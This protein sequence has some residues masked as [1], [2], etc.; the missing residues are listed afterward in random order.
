MSDRGLYSALYGQ[1][2]DC[3][4]LIDDVI[5]DLETAGRVSTEKRRRTLSGYFRALEAAP[6]SNVSAALLWNVLCENKAQ[7]RADWSEV[8]D[9]ID[10]CDASDGVM[11]QL[12]DLAQ[13]LEVERAELN[14][15]IRGSSAR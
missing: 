11:G 9:A 1:L 14:A 5:V 8:A 4:E 10:R 13:L 15:R 2:R 12:K 6:A 3:A 7:Q